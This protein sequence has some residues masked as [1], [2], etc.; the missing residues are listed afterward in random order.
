MKKTLFSH[1][2][3]YIMTGSIVVIGLFSFLTFQIT[4]ER[5]DDYLSDRSLAEREELVERIE[6]AYLGEGNWDDE[7]L[8]GINQNVRHSHIIVRI[9]DNEGNEITSQSGSMRQH[10]RGMQMGEMTPGNDWLEE[11][12]ALEIE[13][14]R[15]GTAFLTYPGVQNYTA[16]EEGFL[17]DLTFLIISMGLFSIALAAVVAYLIS[18]RLSRP[19][20]KTSQMTQELAEGKP[21]DSVP[22]SENIKELSDLHEGMTV[23]AT[24]LAHQKLIRKQQAADLAHEVR[25]PLTTLQGNIE[26]MI[27]G[28]WEVT[29]MRLDSLNHQVKRLTHLVEMIDQL[30]EAEGHQGEMTVESVN[31]KELLN[32]SIM[33]FEQLADKKNLAVSLKCPPVSIEADREKLAQVISNLLANAIK[34]TP[35]GGAISIEA[36]EQDDFLVISVDDTGIGISEEQQPFIFERFYQV[37]PSRHSERPGQGIGL[38]VVKSII[39]AHQ[40]KIEV[41]S[42]VGKG[43]TFTMRL[44]KQQ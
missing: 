30:E 43:T 38:A 21:V 23:L 11:E 14:E 41:K 26:A 36:E 6:T 18:R 25:T 35:S 42:K 44:P 15:I 9:E 7:I 19:I 33:A 22:F 28:V 12:V 2:F 37:E 27:D 32:T 1:L 8:S 34:F 17:R 5:F 4:G 39:E 16:E 13:G 31:I 10:M 20:K 40:G 24:Q 29:P 3:I